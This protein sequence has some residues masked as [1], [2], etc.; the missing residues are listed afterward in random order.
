MNMKIL[1]ASLLLITQSFIAFSQGTLR[2]NVYDKASGEP[3]AYATIKVSNGLGTITD[4]HGFYNIS[5]IPEGQYTAVAS[6]IGY[7]ENSV[8]LNIG[9]TILN[10]VFFLTEKS[11]ELGNVEISARR[12]AARATVQIS[13]VKLTPQQ[14][15]SLPSVG[16]EAD[17]AQYL[18]VLPG[19]ISSGDQGGQIYIRGGSPIQNKILL[20]G[21][22]IYNP[23]HSIGLFSVF[24]TEAVRSID[25]LTGGFGAE[26]G[27]RVSAVVDVKT[28][29]GN[30][31]RLSGL[32]SA[33][34]FLAKAVL[35][36]PI[37]PLKSEGGSS[38]S[39]L[40]TGKYSYLNESSKKIYGY[41]PDSVQLP[42]SFN[43]VYGKISFVSGTGSRVNA[44]GFNFTDRVNFV[45]IANFDWQNSGGG[46]NFSLVPPASKL[47]IGGTISYSDYTSRLR[48]GS[49]DPRTSGIKGFNANLDFTYFGS[50]NELKYGL[51]VNGFR[52]DFQFRNI[53][54]NTISI[55]DNTTEIGGF[56]KYRHSFSRVVIE[57]SL[58]LQYYAS[59][60]DFS[61]EPRL[62][63]KYNITDGLRLKFAGGLYSQNLISTVN[64]RDVVNLFVGYLSGPEATL[65]QPSST[66]VATSRLQKSAHAIFGVEIDVMKNL[67]L[68]IE[69]YLKKFTQLINL[70]RNKRVAT[71]PNFITETGN[72][73]GIDFSMK[74]ETKPLYLWATYSLGYVNR[75]DGKETYPPIFDR[76]HN[77][78]LVSTYRF[79]NNNSWEA[80]GRWNFGTG[81][82]FTLTQGFYGNNGLPNGIGTNVV[83]ENPNLGVIYSNARNSGRLPDYHRLDVSLRK[84]V[85]FSKYLS[86]DIVASATNVYNRQNI[87]YFDRIRYKR[88]NQ[89]PIL[90][91]L[92][93][94]VHF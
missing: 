46:I 54:K 43:D 71:D 67:E 3:V 47:I 90:P 42:Y 10:K 16:G 65:Y 45:N 17:I 88:V 4:I 24:E 66:E 60:G 75:N 6:F 33:N 41:L 72:A 9:K 82:P 61:F 74:Y 57:P 38:V 12:E 28:R 80:S 5:N 73:Y 64:E 92:G 62:G 78:N 55:S 40:L 89:L 37:I 59:L 85:N 27:G 50:N 30:K 76:R 7:E 87:F 8:E 13:T 31:K 81:F 2:G 36:G 56:L 86:M 21:M 34:P 39:F 23:F 77:I 19:V 93:V 11:L 35:E 1:L 53:F 70:N 91:S 26:Y 83:T 68:N 49:E 18:P 58:R 15:K 48:E 79:G 63:A 94:M 25:V 22:T 84:K 51:E 14:I 29:E 44:F 69:P 52:T 20:D 32:V